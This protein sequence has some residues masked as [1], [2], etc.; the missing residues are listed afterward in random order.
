MEAEVGKYYLVKCLQY[1]V[2]GVSAW[3]PIMGERLAD[4]EV[5]NPHP[6]YHVDYRFM[7]LAL[8]SLFYKGGFS[9]MNIRVLYDSDGT[10][11]ISYRR[12]RCYR[13]FGHIR[14]IG[15]G[16]IGGLDYCDF[17]TMLLKGMDANSVRTKERN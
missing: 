11:P 17:E 7:S 9:A 1:P 15:E 5:G 16:I 3:I 2:N 4:P 14:P 8:F 13:N 6:H 12:L 10:Y